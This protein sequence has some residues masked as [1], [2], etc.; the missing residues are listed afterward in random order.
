MQEPLAVL[1]SGCKINLFLL[2]GEKLANGYHNLE[3]LFLP[4]EEPHDLLEIFP[5]AKGSGI[6]VSFSSQKDGAAGPAI[7]PPDNNTLTKAWAA[8]AKAS[9]FMPD[10][11]V[12]VLKR[13]PTGGGL[14]GG[15]AN[16]AALLNWLQSAAKDQGRAPLEEKILAEIALSIGADLP[17][18]LLN[19]P[20]L[21]SGVGQKLSP[22][23]VAFSESFLVLVC[24]DIAVQTAWGFKALDEKRAGQT[25][26]QT[27]RNN[28]GKKSALSVL[29]SEGQQASN[30][31]ARAAGYG[32]DFE[33]L[34]FP[35]YPELGQ[36]YERLAETGAL[37]VRMSGTG[38]TLFA[39]YDDEKIAA[40]VTKALANDGLNVYM[41][42]LSGVETGS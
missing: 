32:N 8:Y 24:P 14:G 11:A 10:I 37:A 26:Q 2:I 40:R 28:A 27:G 36:L 3:S 13:V 34:V 9:G 39:I 19:K 31:L 22:C 17:F 29:T 12:H 35:V 30:F 20:A 21:V 42:R 38:S 4:L 6:T 18:F 7:A 23:P 41:Q 15:S 1:R 16:G 33:E 25:S 5:A